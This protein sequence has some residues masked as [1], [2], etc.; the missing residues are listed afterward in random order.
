MG[1]S[2]LRCRPIQGR[3]GI[4]TPN[5]DLASSAPMVT[6][7]PSFL[8]E[9]LSRPDWH[10]DPSEDRSTGGRASQLKPPFPVIVEA[11]AA[12]SR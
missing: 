12:R 8:T 3:N 7:L 6:T 11:G 5:G 9:R 1:A 4:S 2:E 10:I